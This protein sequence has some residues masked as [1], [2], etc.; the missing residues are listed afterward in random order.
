M[1]SSHSELCFGLTKLGLDVG[2]A[3]CRP[4]AAEDDDKTKHAT[5]FKTEII[6]NTPTEVFKQ[7]SCCLISLLMTWKLGCTVKQSLQMKRTLFRLI[8]NEEGLGIS[9]PPNQAEGN[10]RAG[11][12]LRRQM[13]NS[14]CRKEWFEILLDFSRV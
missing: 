5:F 9:E 3:V 7:V 6:N 14:P 2:V 1:K 10:I 11:E 4:D 13:Q 8:T 12:T